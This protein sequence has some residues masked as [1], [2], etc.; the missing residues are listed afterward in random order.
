MAINKKK[1]ENTILFIGNELGGKIDGKKK[2]AK[3][4][5]YI[6]FDRYEY[7][8]S[9]ESVTG[10]T[11][12]AWRMGPVPQKYM[13]MVEKMIEDGLI[14]RQICDL[15]PGYHAQENFIVRAEPDLSIFDEDDLNIMHRVIK[16]YGALNG[17]QLEVLTHQEAPWA[18]VEQSGII[19]YELA[20]YRGT[21]FSD[22]V[23]V[24]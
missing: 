20:F 4:L 22:V 24:A 13:D 18:G 16:K 9:M 23:A 3:L 11:Y 5:Y 12:Q 2:L 6:D 10:D 8:E 14:E 17:K 21:D 19:P 15:G 1:Y 7:K